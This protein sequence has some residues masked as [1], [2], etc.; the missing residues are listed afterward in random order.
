MPRR[1]LEYCVREEAIGRNFV[2]E[3]APDEED[4][5]VLKPMH[6]AFYQTPHL[7]EFICRSAK[8][9]DRTC[10]LQNC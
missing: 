2:Q 5:F 3:I 6:S 9:D 8:H 4:Y 10:R 7:R 1:I